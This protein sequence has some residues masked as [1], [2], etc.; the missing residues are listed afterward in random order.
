MQLAAVIVLI[1]AALVGLEWIL[2]NLLALRVWRGM[3]HLGA[4]YPLTRQDWPMLSIVV[5]ARNERANIETCLTSLLRQDYPRFEIIVVNDRSTDDTGDIARRL[6]AADSRLRVIDIDHL[7][8]GWC[9]KN[10]AMQRGIERATAPWILMQDADCRHIHPST[11]RLAMQHALDTEADM[12]SLLPEHQYKTFWEGYLLPIL[13]G[14]LMIWFRPSRVNDP[15]RRVAFANGMFMLIRRE[16]YEAVGTHEAVRGS[17]IEDMDLARLVKQR[18]LRLRVTPSTGL[19]HVR[20]YSSLEQIVQGWER[21]LL[22]SFRHLGGL[23]KAALVLVGRGLT[24]AVTAAIACG[25]VA[26]G[27]APGGWWR[28]AAI[29]GAVSLLAQLVMAARFY[30]HLKSKCYYGLTYPF[31]CAMAATILVTTMFKLRPGGKIVWRD[32]VYHLQ[33]SRIANRDSRIRPT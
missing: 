21:I 6:A 32:T 16:A 33:E 28:A 20:M 26:A 7:P 18:G 17:L 11:L 29:V 14:M 23:T 22:G 2:R 8:D 15:R 9:G 3:F 30:V 27:A 19:F 1:L 25:M 10:H 24:P 5:A 4:G 13:T 12:L 31:G